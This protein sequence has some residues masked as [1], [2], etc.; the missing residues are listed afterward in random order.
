VRRALLTLTHMGYVVADD[1]AYRLAP[2]VLTLATAYL[3]TNPRST[4]RHWPSSKPCRLPCE[5]L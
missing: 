3:T 1:K 5:G 2:K 4:R